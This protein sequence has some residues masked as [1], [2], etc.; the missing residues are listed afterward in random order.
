MFHN[1]VTLVTSIYAFFI[2]Q[3]FIGIIKRSPAV[4]WRSP[5]PHRAD[6]EDD[7]KYA[8]T[9]IQTD[10]QWMEHKRR[11]GDGR[12]SEKKKAYSFRHKLWVGCYFDLKTT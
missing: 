2:K 11:G 4:P 10:E 1:K 8:H 3:F 9:Y 12:H 7:R 5:P 6:N